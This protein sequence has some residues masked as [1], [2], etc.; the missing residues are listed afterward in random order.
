MVD[1]WRAEFDKEQGRGRP[2]RAAWRCAYSRMLGSEAP[3]DVSQCAAAL[4][5]ELAAR[6]GSGKLDV[7]TA[8]VAVDLFLVTGD[9]A[10]DENRTD[11][12][13]KAVEHVIEER[14]RAGEDDV[15]AADRVA[16]WVLTIKAY[17][18]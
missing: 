16:M 15:M 4:R 10:P 14:L 18:H 11:V 1:A 7:R 17:R 9:W 5:A 2:E 13:L 6:L 3:P 8:G 12:L